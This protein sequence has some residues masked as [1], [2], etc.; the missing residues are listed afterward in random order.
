MS[1]ARRLTDADETIRTRPAP[2]ESP[3]YSSKRPAAVKPRPEITVTVNPAKGVAQ[4]ETRPTIAKRTYAAAKTVDPRSRPLT[5]VYKVG[6]GDVLFVNLKNSARGSG[7]YTVRANGTIDFPLAGENVIVAGQAV[8]SIK[9]I[10]ESGITLFRD[11]Q[12]EVTVR[13]YGSHKVTVSGMV[14]NPGEKSLQREAIPLFVIRADAVVD[15]KATRAI[16]TRGPLLKVETCDLRDANTD[17]ILIYPGN[18]VEFTN[19]NG[20]RENTG[21]F[22]YIGGE[23]IS[24]GQKQLSSG[25]TLYQAIVASGGSKGDPKKAIIRRKNDKGVFAIFEHNLRA[26]RD[27]K[28]ADPTLTAGDIVE[29]RN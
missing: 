9:E 25:L 4:A 3:K 11:P 14:D 21:N 26:I 27:G 29:I 18:S 13:E 23:V 5:G 6:V 2:A 1:T 8:D 19:E 20:S 22:Y 16:I 7:Y 24:A 12:V 28:A 10:L 15:P 17:G